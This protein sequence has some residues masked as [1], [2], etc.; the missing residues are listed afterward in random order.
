[1]I[2]IDIL[3]LR[4]KLGPTPVGGIM[5]ID[6]VA[7]AN[8]DEAEAERFYG[9]LLGLAR[10][11]DFTIDARLAERLFAVAR[12][13]KVVTFGDGRTRI[14]VFIAPEMVSPSPMVPHLCVAVQDPAGTAGRAEALGLPVVRAEREGRTLYFVRDR[15]GNAVELKAAGASRRAGG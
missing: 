9:D 11:Y 12:D 15:S 2:D 5:G 13:V 4:M 1:M 14:E 3:F 8:R 10:L 6:H 7:M